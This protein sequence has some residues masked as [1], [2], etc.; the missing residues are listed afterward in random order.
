M[1]GMSWL[2]QDYYVFCIL[3][4]LLPYTGEPYQLSTSALSPSELHAELSRRYFNLCKMDDDPE[5]Q[6]AV[7]LRCKLDINYFVNEFCYTFDPRERASTLPFILFPKQADYLSW[8]S[9]LEETQENGLAEKCR[10]VGFTWLSCV[11]VLHRFLFFSGRKFGFGSRKLELVDNL[12]EPDSIFEKF[13][14]LYRHLPKWMM[15]PSFIPSKHDHINKIVNPNNNSMVSGEG[16]DNIG[17]GGRTSMYFVDESAFIERAEKVEGALSQNTRVTVDISTPNGPGNA[18][19]RKRHSG[20]VSVFEFDW[21]DDP[22]KNLWNAFSIPTPDSPS[23]YLAS[24]HG[25]GEDAPPLS[26]LIYPWYEKEKGRLDPVILAQEIDRDYTASIEGITIPGIWIRAA[27]NLQLPFD[28]MWDKV[29][30]LDVSDSGKN[31]SV[32][33]QRQGPILQ[34]IHSWRNKNTTETANFAVEYCN[35]YHVDAL[36]YDCVGV[37]AGVKGALASL[38]KQPAFSI[39]GING[40]EPASKAKW[41][42]GRTSTQKFLNIRAE[43]YWCLRTRFEKTWEYVTLGVQHPIEDLISIPNHQELISQLSQPLYFSTQTGKIKIESKTDMKRRGIQS[44]DFADMLSYCFSPYNGV[45]R[46]SLEEAK[47]VNELQ[48]KLTFSINNVGTNW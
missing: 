27:I 38:D 18:F 9:I 44:P 39:R 42:D 13:R 23:I 16:G 25:W 26:R 19:Y 33:G 10:D 3:I 24:G 20:L 6:A 2:W 34:H 30:G 31:Q 12:D 41:P 11:F 43:S 47:K 29:A 37:G 35:K 28:S 32:F 40:G 36:N 8:L 7:L 21:K 1:L 17:R 45:T 15:P 48:K 4:M 5:L 22:R 46:K 14:F